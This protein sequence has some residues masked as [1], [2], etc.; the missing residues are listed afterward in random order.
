MHCFKAKTI[1]VDS[2]STADGLSVRRRR[3]CLNCQKRFT[4]FETAQLPT[5]LVVKNDGTKEPLS[6]R[7]I[8]EG[9]ML[10]IQKT[11]LTPLEAQRVVDKIVQD[12]IS[13]RKPE[14]SSKKI[15]LAVLNELESINKVAYLRFKSVYLGFKTI[16]GFEKEITTLLHKK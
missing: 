13:S 11:N 12:I 9:I 3:E 5:V 16:A 1:V 8:L 15:G 7:K 6:R 10:A 14:I 4:T 2:R